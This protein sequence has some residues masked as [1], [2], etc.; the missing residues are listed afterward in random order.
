MPAPNLQGEFNPPVQSRV[1][2]GRGKAATLKDEVDSL[3]GRRVLLLSGKTVAEKTDAVQIAAR[4]LGGR[5]VSIYS[6]LTQRAPLATS[7]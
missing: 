1:I 7:K 4:G 2:F 6:E 5:C 3:G